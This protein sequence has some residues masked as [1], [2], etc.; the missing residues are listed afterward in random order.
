MSGL[1]GRAAG[2]LERVRQVLFLGEYRGG[3][4]V[5]MDRLGNKYYEVVDEVRMRPCKRLPRKA[6]GVNTV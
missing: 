6:A 3:Q 1:R 4:L 5:G 2:L